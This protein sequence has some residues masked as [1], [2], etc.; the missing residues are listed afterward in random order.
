M[1]I[2]EP[3]KPKM[4]KKSFRLPVDVWDVIKELSEDHNT[5]ESVVIRMI[6]LNFINDYKINQ[7]EGK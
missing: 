3:K 6:L 1:K 7:Y 2:K 5:T 4:L